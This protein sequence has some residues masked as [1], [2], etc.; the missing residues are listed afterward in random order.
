[1]IY[2]RGLIV[3]GWLDQQFRP[4]LAIFASIFTVFFAMKKIG[5]KINVTYTIISEG[6]SH[7]RIS[8]LIFQNK[9]DKPVSIYKIVAIFDKNYY[10]E[11]KNCSPP[12][13]LKPYESISVETE[14]FSHLSINSDRYFPNFFEAD[15]HIESDEKIIKCNAK[16]HKDHVYEYTQI[17]K[18]T[19]KFNN[20]VYD[21]YIA[22]ILV[23]SVKNIDK[24]AFISDT[25]S[26]KQEWDFYFN[27]IKK[28]NGKL[29]VDEI[30]QFL[31]QNYSKAIDA[32][33]LYKVNDQTLELDLL[34]QHNFEKV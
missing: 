5:N 30:C 4:I 7:T 17:S 28:R 14:Q 25:G 18:T 10:L 8:N 6:T 24:T 23:Y 11:I 33:L 29:Q 1:M 32:Y 9:K 3:W 27:R 19:K 12:L 22:Y 26:I 13:I 20:I 2:E 15:I 34:K 16:T 31:N 21:D